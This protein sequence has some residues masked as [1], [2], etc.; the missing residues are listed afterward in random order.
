MEAAEPAVPA[1]R[2][3]RPRRVREIDFSR[4]NKFTPDQTR[5]LERAHD[6]FCRTAST[7]LS[8]E[9]RTPIVLELANTA[10][11]TWSRALAELPPGALFGILDAQPMGSRMLFAADLE[12]VMRMIDRLLGGSGAT[13]VDRTELTAIETALA[14]RLFTTVLEPLSYAWRELVEVELSLAG[15]ESLAANAQLAP[16]SEPTFALSFEAR[17][18]GTTSTM[19]LVI[20][21]RAVEPVVDRIAR[22]GYSEDPADPGAQGAAAAAVR[23]ALAGVEVELRAEAGAIEMSVAELMALRPG[24]IVPLNASEQSGVTVYADASA[25][26]RGKPG[27]SGGRR[28]VQVIERLERS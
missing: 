1:A 7:H 20:P 23:T 22:T 16:A 21:Y 25:L 26:H 11:L 6:A 13:R 17:I 5:R 9:L 10:Q 28:A 27:R 18:D 19:A 4:P 12:L 15:L 24:Q 8:A 2:N 3:G 14:R